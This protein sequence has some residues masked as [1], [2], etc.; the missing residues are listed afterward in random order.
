MKNSRLQD[1]VSRIVPTY[2]ALPR[3]ECRASVAR[4]GGVDI[5]L[6]KELRGFY[7][8]LTGAKFF[9][10]VTVRATHGLPCGGDHSPPCAYRYVVAVRSEGCE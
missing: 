6:Y 3:S 1:I 4:S 5:L 2:P 10:M 8:G 7:G 9:G